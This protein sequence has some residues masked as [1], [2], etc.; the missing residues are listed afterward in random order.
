[1]KDHICQNT[2]GLLKTNPATIATFKAHDE[3]RLLE[4][5][6]QGIEPK[7]SEGLHLHVGGVVLL[8]AMGERAEADRLLRK[9]LDEPEHAK[10]AD[11]WRLAAE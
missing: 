11:L 7:E 5:A 6:L 10:R 8:Q 1:M 2:H 4:R 9:V 3:R